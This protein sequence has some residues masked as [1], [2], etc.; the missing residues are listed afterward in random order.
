MAKT[1]F[2]NNT[3][4]IAYGFAVNTTVASAAYLYNN[5]E[6]PVQIG[7]V[8]TPASMAGI[9][10]NQLLD[11]GGVQVTVS[12]VTE[13]AFIYSPLYLPST[14]TSIRTPWLDIGPLKYTQATNTISFSYYAPATHDLYFTSL[15]TPDSGEIT[16][17]L[18]GEFL[19]TFSLYN[20]VNALLSVLLSADVSSG[21]HQLSITAG[22]PAP[23]Q[24]FVY[25]SAF[26]LLEHIPQTGGF[27]SHLGPAGNL[28]DS[29]N[30]F[31]GDWSTSGNYAFS[32]AAGSSVFFYPQLD[33]GGEIKIRVQ[34]T[35]DSG[36]V[37]VFLDGTEIQQLDLYANPGLNPTDITLLSQPPVTEGLHEIELRLTP[38][39]NPASTGSL[40][41]FRGAVVV[42]TRTDL[43]ALTLSADYL[44]K[45]ATQLQDGAFPDAYDSSRINFD[46]T[47]LYACMG[48]LAAYQVLGTPEYLLAVKD[49]LVWFAQRQMLSPSDSFT[50]GA[51]NIGYRRLPPPVGGY[52]PA[53]APYDAQGITEIRWVDA[54]QCLP[55]FVLHWYTKLSGDIS[56]RTL[57]LPAFRNGIDGFIRNNYDPGSAFFYSSWQLKTTPTMFLYH[58]AV[59]HRDSDGTV[60]AVYND[61]NTNFFTYTPSAAWGSYGPVEAVNADEH[62]CLEPGSQVAFSLVLAAGEQV[63]WKTQTAWD[64]CI[65]EALVSPDGFDFSSLGTFDCYSPVSEFQQMFTIFSATTAGTYWFRIR[66]TG[67]IN[68]AGASG[69]GWQ[70][71]AARYSAGQTDVALGLL[72]LWEMTRKPRYAALAARLLRRFN[73]KFWL[74]SDNRWALALEGPSPGAQ[75][76][77]WYPF[78]QGYTAFGQGNYRYFY[79]PS[80]MQAALSSLEAHQDEEGGFD[81]PGFSEPEHIFSAFYLL[82]RNTLGSSQSS[83]E[84]QMAKNFIK[85]GQYL[86]ELDNQLVAGVVFSKRYPYLYCNIAG[87]ACLALAGALSPTAGLSPLLDQI[88]ISHSD[89]WMR[90]A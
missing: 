54:V 51:W 38:D 16:V 19:G 2:P 82:G 3:Y 89:L 80:S 21:E 78:P 11:I 73:S 1:I 70:R 24:H 57:L 55:A 41:Y 27:Y 71:L 35:P 65:A 12:Q 47:S 49:F 14:G 25:F 61:S 48:L 33:L 87:F 62:Y 39:N 6:P 20:A 72:A 58:D 63:V 53:I 76:T 83:A 31:L 60:I 85:S 46:A 81:L 44:L 28:E 45:V 34:K 18:D 29:T 84:Y 7:V 5:A 43:Q 52:A 86:L 69:L 17:N 90:P 77:A 26:E 30:N 75:N 40:F 79:P 64:V 56:T 50:D 8:V 36:I 22:F 67:T 32:S 10:E 13:S 15:K 59:E 42:F 68:P 9:A 74:D 37:S 88:A 4:E 23:S 66:H